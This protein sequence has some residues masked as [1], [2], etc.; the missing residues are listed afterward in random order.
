MNALF[1]EGAPVPSRGRAMALFN[2][3]FNVGITIAAFAAGE[4]AERFG[5]SAMWLAMGAAGALGA[6]AL[7]IDRPRLELA[8]RA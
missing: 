7:V 1:V 2:L 6:L 8:D 5:Y 4:I 3:A